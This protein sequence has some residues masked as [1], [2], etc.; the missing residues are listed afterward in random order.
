[1]TGNIATAHGSGVYIQDAS[2]S[3]YISNSNFTSNQS[4]NGNGGCYSS[5]K[6]PYN[7]TIIK[8]NNAK[9]GAGIHVHL[10]L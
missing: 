3:L 2:S 7:D 6:T 1:M 8:S 9:S 4:P 10:G 5:F